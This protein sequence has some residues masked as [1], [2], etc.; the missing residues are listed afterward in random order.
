MKSH[1]GERVYVPREV[2]LSGATTD[3]CEQFV[4]SQATDAPEGFHN[5]TLSSWT[6]AHHPTLPVIT[7]LS[8][9]CPSDGDARQLGWLLGYPITSAGRLLGTGS[10]VTVADADPVAFVDSLGGRFLAVFVD[11]PTPAIYP[12]AVGSYSSV[13][14]PDLGIAASTPGLIPYEETTGD[15]LDLV[16]QLRIPWTNSMYPL[17]LTPRHGVHRLLPNHHLDLTDWTMVRHGP[18]WHERGSVSIDE[19]VSRVAA[20]V[21]R[22][23]AAVTDTHPSYLQL[24][25][26]NDS[27][28]LLACAREWRSDLATYTLKFPDLGGMND[29]RVAARLSELAGVSHRVVPTD[30]PDPADLEMWVYRTSCSVGEPQG[31]RAAT[32]YQSLERSRAHIAGNVG[33][34]ARIGYWATIGRSGRPV[35]PEQLAAHALAHRLPRLNPGQQRAAASTTVLEEIERWRDTS[36]APDAL[37][38]LDLLF[39]ENRLACWA[40]IWPYAQYYGPGF[41]YFPMNHR[42]VIDL[43]MGLPEAV[44]RGEKFNQ[45][46]IRQEWPELLD[47]PF[48][49]P[50]RSVRLAQLPARVERGLRRRV[51]SM[52]KPGAQ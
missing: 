2:A 14:C 11:G 8:D 19:S 3:L 26:G 12:D 28:M 44:R 5:E 7:I 25:A 45:M 42:E 37:A 49:T 43:M 24:T 52:R 1:A 31:W 36:G 34:L 16:D 27:R 17:G 6:L 48:N 21:K 29:A 20:I 4:L 46:V 22:N 35:T 23:I 13:F 39:V 41:T 15:R 10:T 18:N 51:R 33:D 30:H 40:G 32:A 50:S 38:L 9:T 47:V